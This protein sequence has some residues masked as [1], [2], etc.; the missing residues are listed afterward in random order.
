[1]KSCYV[2][3]VSPVRIAI[4]DL[5]DYYG[6]GWIIT[7]INVPMQFRGKGFGSELL[8]QICSDADKEKQTLFLE[9]QSSDGL[10]YREL[11]EW[12]LRYG[13]RNCKG[14]YKR[15]PA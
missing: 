7:R 9:I 14:I 12:Y 6:E 15:N 3:Q 10:S 2:I 1:M 4:A 11:E 8:K 5:C 13:F